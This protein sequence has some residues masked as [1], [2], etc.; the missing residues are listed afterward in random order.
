M[1]HLQTYMFKPKN[2]IE[3]IKETTM[4]T[5]QIKTYLIKKGEVFVEYFYSLC[6]D[7]FFIFALVIA[8][9]RHV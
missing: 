1:I 4:E 3:N 6:S 8:Q 7:F 9:K 2:D 5:T